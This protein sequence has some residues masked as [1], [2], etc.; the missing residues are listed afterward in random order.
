MV[1]IISSIYI[2]ETD[3]KQR[4]FKTVNRCNYNLHY[5]YTFKVAGISYLAGI[6]QVTMRK[7]QTIL[8]II[9]ICLLTLSYAQDGK[10]NIEYTPD[11]KQHI[12]RTCLY[13]GG[14]DSLMKDI[15]KN[16]SIPKQAVKDKIDGK[17][18]LQ[19]IVDTTGIASGKILKGLRADVDSAAIDMTKKLKR[20]VPATMD[21]R[22]VPMTLNVPLKL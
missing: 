19:I 16:F 12:T 6:K 4:N 17:V 20:F 1:L 14:K 8:T 13:P 9:F 11:N 2:N 21:E 5:A 3:A 15:A 22:K 10:T 18:Y 7:T